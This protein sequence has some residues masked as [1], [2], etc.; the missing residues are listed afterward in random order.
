MY[1]PLQVEDTVFFCHPLEGGDPDLDSRFRGNDAV[2][3]IGNSKWNM[4]KAVWLILFFI[5]NINAQPQ[6]GYATWG[7]LKYSKNF[8]NFDYVN[9]K[10]SKGGVLTMGTLGSFDSLNPLIIQG[11]PCGMVNSLCFARLLK[12]SEDSIAQSY[13]YVAESVEISDDFSWIEFKI[14]KDATFSDNTPITAEDVIFS[15][16]IIREKGLPMYRTY[17]KAI[18]KVEK[19]DNH[20]VRF[21]VKDK[22]N[23]ELPLILGQLPILS[24]QYYK[25]KNFEKSSLEP[26]PCSGPYKID[27]VDQGHSITFK[28]IEGWW[29]EK[30]GSCV[31]MYNFDQFKLE[32]YRDSNAAFEAFKVG[33]LDIRLENSARIWNTAYNFPAFKEGKIKKITIPNKMGRGTVGIFFNTRKLYLN[34]QKIRQAITMMFHFNWLNKTI[35][36]NEFKRC[37]SYFCDTHLADHENKEITLGYPA[38]APLPREVLEK[39]KKLFNEAGWTINSGQMIK[40]DQHFPELEFVI[41]NPELQKIALHLAQNLEQIGI[42]LTVRLLDSSAYQEKLDKYD[43]DLVYE[44]IPQ[45]L[46]PGNEQRDYFGSYAAAKNG[47]KNFAGVQDKDVDE[48]IEDI[49][50]ASDSNTQV[51]LVQK[52]DKLLLDGYY[53]IPNWHTQG[54]WTA[55]WSKVK[56]PDISPAYTNISLFSWWIDDDKSI[57]IPKSQDLSCYQKIIRFLGV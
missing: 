35:F 30:V 27:K 36:Y 55:Y 47:S 31:G 3:R 11:N 10:A 40:N 38:D 50:Q 1:I 51:K 20:T 22:K 12:E 41:S 17:Y 8:T 4:Y 37:Y 43:Y 57:T 42:K 19:I 53:M 26:F 32:Y 15:F 9:P 48:V 14:K 29:G 52:L 21:I 7:N 28:R 44:I 6:H 39:S 25:H 13:V 16:N 54:T 49:I 34:D 46:T 56:M 23:K 2:G 24:H 45:S 5:I 18:S 33:K